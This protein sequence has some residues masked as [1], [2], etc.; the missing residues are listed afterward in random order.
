MTNEEANKVI[1][2][3]MGAVFYETH[4]PS[5]ILIL[6]GCEIRIKGFDRYT[7]SLDALVPVWERLKVRDL[8][9]LF[10]IRHFFL[11]QLSSFYYLLFF[12]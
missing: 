8:K 1:A 9:F 10:L 7:N 5:P 6:D 12:V 3:Y 11:Y 4:N 2:E